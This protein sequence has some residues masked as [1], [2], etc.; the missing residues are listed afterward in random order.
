MKV[1]KT[2]TVLAWAA[3]PFIFMEILTNVPGTHIYTYLIPGTVLVAYGITV[4]ESFVVKL[5]KEKIG[6]IINVLGLTVAFVFTFYLPHQIF[7]DH[8][9]H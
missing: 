8:S 2:W 4:I 1:K 3:F 9:F 5:F 7:V 6:T